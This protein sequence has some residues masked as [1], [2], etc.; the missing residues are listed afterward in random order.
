MFNSGNNT[1]LVLHAM[2]VSYTSNDMPKFKKDLLKVKK[3]HHIMF[4]RDL[5]LVNK[6]SYNYINISLR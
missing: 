2:F 4:Q 6:L 5:C 3:S 1:F